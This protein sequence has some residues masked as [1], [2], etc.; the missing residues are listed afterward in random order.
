NASGSP[1]KNGFAGENGER[2]PDQNE[3]NQVS[4]R[5]WF[6]IKEY[7]EKERANRRKILEKTDGDE[8]EMSGRVT[9]PE[10]RNGGND[11]GAD[12]QDRQRRADATEHERAGVLKIE[13]ENNREWDK[14]DRFDEQTGNGA[15]AGLFSE[16]S[17][18]SEG[19]AERN[20]DPRE[21]AI[22]EGEIQ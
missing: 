2:E 4:A 9:E 20:G 8:A 16:Q 12:E 19:D 10:E 18:K 7:A 14:Q 1:A 21:A 13:E 17:I 15:G 5:K 6:V 11:A 3:S 22:T